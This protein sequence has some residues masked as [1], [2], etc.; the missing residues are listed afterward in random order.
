MEDAMEF[1]KEF[2]HYIRISIPKLF[3]SAIE[4][5][6]VTPARLAELA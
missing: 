5:T 1:L 3:E 2:P 4:F 6:Q